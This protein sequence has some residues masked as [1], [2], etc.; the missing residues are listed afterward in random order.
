M[1]KIVLVIEDSADGKVKVTCDPTFETMML[2]AKAGKL[3]SS[4]G[5][6]YAAIN[7][8]RKESQVRQPSLIKIPRLRL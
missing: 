6:A 5:Y 3:E 4:H 1:A 8:I 7:A 2:I